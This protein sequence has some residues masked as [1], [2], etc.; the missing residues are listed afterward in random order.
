MVLLYVPMHS[1]HYCVKLS[2]SLLLAQWRLV[3]PENTVLKC[4][5]VCADNI[6]SVFKWVYKCSESV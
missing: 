1:V 4:A 6:T 5:N 2:F 3:P